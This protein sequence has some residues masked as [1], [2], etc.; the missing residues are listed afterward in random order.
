MSVYSDLC[1]HVPGIYN[2][3][4]TAVGFLFV[5]LVFRLLIIFFLFFRT[6]GSPNYIKFHIYTYEIL[7]LKLQM[8][9][10]SKFRLSDDSQRR[11]I[12]HLCIFVVGI[13]FCFLV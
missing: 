4:R 11:I 6:S 10:N 13:S 3:C 7:N 2:M 8:F 9:L 5:R 1:L 12:S